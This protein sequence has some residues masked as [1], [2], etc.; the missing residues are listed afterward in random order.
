M[1]FS[2][3]KDVNRKQYQNFLRIVGS[4]SN[5]FSDSNI[6]Y[7]YYRIAEKIFCRAF[8]AEDLSRSD[9]SID[10]KKKSIGIG[11]KTF[12]RGNNKTFQKIAEFN[13]DRKLY[14]NF[15]PKD[16]ITKISE[17]RN[18][19]LNFTENL[20]AIDDSIYH[21][22]VRDQNIFKIF[23]KKMSK[24]D[25]DNISNIKTNKNSII[26]SDGISQ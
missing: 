14:T 6:P 10:A 11:L 15:S 18:N 1:F 3:Q 2:H 17:L 8:N 5:L 9:V 23:E 13:A 21:C 26:F 7:L 24:I 12:L 20:H 22:I 16:L 19:R 25:I 4:L